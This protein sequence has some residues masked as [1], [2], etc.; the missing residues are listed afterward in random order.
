MPTVS[1][2]RLTFI[3]KL[4]PNVMFSTPISH[5]IQTSDIKFSIKHLFHVNSNDVSFYTKIVKTNSYAKT[6]KNKIN[7]I[8]TDDATQTITFHLTAKNKTF[9]E[10]IAMPFA[11]AMPKDT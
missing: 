5:P 2:N 9:L 4:R 1:K 7:K 8:M 10:Y 3:F 6:H 11:F